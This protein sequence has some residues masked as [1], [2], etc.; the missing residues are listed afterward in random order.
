LK[1]FNKKQVKFL[2]VF[3]Y[4]ILEHLDQ[5]FIIIVFPARVAEAF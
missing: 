2:A 3:K 5:Y 1:P 4:I